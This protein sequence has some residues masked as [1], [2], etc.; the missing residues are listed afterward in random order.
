MPLAPCGQGR[1]SLGIWFYV[2]FAGSGLLRVSLFDFESE[3][4]RLFLSQWY[5]FFVEHGRWQGLSELDERFASYPPLY[6]Y[7][8]SLSTLLPLPKLYAVK[9]L[10]IASDY[11]AAWYLWRLGGRLCPSGWGAWA[12]LRVF[13]VG[14]MTLRVGRGCARSGWRD[15]SVTRSDRRRREL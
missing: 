11:L 9:L 15:E 2:S 12:T 13:L 1:G 4:Y 7:L 8:I 14:A 10:S 5:Y 6:M 3:D